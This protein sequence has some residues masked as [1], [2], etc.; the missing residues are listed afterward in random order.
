MVETVALG[1]AGFNALDDAA[2]ERL[3]LS[4]C[5]CAA[6]AHMV[7]T[8]RPYEA[9]DDL[10]AAAARAVAAL[11]EREL[12]DALAGHPR[13]GERPSRPGQDGE[14]SGR[15][16]AGMQGASASTAR[17]I[18]DG[19][20]VYEERFGQVY[21]VC[22]TGL[23]ADELLARLRRRLSNDPVTERAVVREELRRIN[24]LRLARLVL[25]DPA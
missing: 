16:Q 9:P 20:R 17:E 11:T 1:L 14:L 7:A 8:G 15:E 2:A 6:W 10:Y 25:G 5:S 3:L 21:L 4:C 24:E 12:D 22:A 18:A 23:D 19:N 13:I